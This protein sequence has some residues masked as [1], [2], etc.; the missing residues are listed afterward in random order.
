MERRADRTILNVP[1]RYEL[2][3]SRHR[4][5]MGKGF[6]VILV[7]IRTSR[8]HARQGCQFQATKICTCID[9]SRGDTD[10]CF[11]SARVLSH[12]SVSSILQTNPEQTTE[13]GAFPCLEHKFLW[14]FTCPSSSPCRRIESLSHSPSR[15]YIRLGKTRLKEKNGIGSFV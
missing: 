15:W 12:L 13:W 14:F 11:A 3:K 9:A 1:F 6:F 4:T 7:S 10:P 5:I 8:S 2:P